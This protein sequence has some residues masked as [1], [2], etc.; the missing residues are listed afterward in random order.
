MS[1]RD[2]IPLIRWHHERPDGHGYPDGLH[3]DQI[4]L[5]V[6]ML[7]VADVYDSLSSDRPYRNKMPHETC[8]RILRETA[9]DGGLDPELV[10]TLEE[11]VPCAP[12]SDLNA[13]TALLTPVVPSRHKD[14]FLRP[15]V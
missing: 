13:E 2:A 9:L 14:V 11:I 6:R 12:E 1:V 8:L 15:Q 7:S 3:G 4:P 5:L 10:A